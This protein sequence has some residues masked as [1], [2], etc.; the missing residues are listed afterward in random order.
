METVQEFRVG[1][2][3]S[4]SAEQGMDPNHPGCLANTGTALQ[5]AGIRTEKGELCGH[6]GNG[7][8]VFRYAVGI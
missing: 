7:W 2:I 6:G 5:S 1:I 8:F 4:L 3:L